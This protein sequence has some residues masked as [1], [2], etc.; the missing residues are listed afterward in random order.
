M[1]PRV[2]ME[3]AASIFGFTF[4]GARFFLSFLDRFVM[5]IVKA[6]WDISVVKADANELISRA[7]RRSWKSQR[8]REVAILSRS[9]ISHFVKDVNDNRRTS[10]DSHLL[11]VYSPVSNGQLMLRNVLQLV[12]FPFVGVFNS[13][14][15]PICWKLY[16]ISAVIMRS[17]RL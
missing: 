13:A 15:F 9:A 8:R 12:L 1:K 6:E 17:D 11:L 5:Q 3:R 4:N 14:L 16:A 7:E 10:C 2:C